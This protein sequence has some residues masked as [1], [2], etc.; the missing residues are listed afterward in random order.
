MKKIIRVFPGRTSY[1]P[2]DAYAFV[3]MPPMEQ[4]IPEHDEVHVSCTFSWDKEYAEDLQYQW[5]GRTDKPVKLGGPAFNSPA[6]DFVPGMYTKSN[7]IFTTR[8]CDNSCPWCIVPK[9]EGRLKELPVYL[10]NWV[11]D[12]NFLQASR[13]HKDKV[14]DMLRTQKG[15]CFKGGLEADLIDDVV[16]F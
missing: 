11:Q 16:S 7:I 12:N 2:D 1:T 14:F 10:G 9:L 3:G 6:T 15:I 8:G 13:Q 4:L 5:E